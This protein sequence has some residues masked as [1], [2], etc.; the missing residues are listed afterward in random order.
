[1]DQILL[2]GEPQMKN[3]QEP[4]FDVKFALGLYL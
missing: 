1:M 4:V 3:I 2:V